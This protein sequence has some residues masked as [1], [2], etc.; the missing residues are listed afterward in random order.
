MFANAY[1]SSLGYLWSIKR[2]GQ[3]LDIPTFASLITSVVLFVFSGVTLVSV[4]LVIS[5]VSA[6]SFRWFRF[7]VCGLVHATK[8]KG[9]DSGM[10]SSLLCPKY[11]ENKWLVDYESW[12]YATSKNKPRD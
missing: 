5:L 1:I 12:Y 10:T 7:V 9:L 11:E 4:V 8:D 2:H 3:F 6:V